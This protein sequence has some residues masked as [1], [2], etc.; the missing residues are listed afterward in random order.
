MMAGEIGERRGV[1][2]T[3]C[4]GIVSAACAFT[5]DRV[6]I[7]FGRCLHWNVGRNNPGIQHPDKNSE[8]RLPPAIHLF[9]RTQ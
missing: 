8:L 7:S 4:L 2:C 6:A 1:W 9:M 5:I 3:R